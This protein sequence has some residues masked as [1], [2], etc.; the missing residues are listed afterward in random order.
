M[1]GG[2][3]DLTISREANEAACNFM[4]TKTALTVKDP[5]KA[6]KLMPSEVFAR[7]PVCDGGYYEQFN[8]EN[9]NI[10]NIG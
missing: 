5:E 9:V 2:F 10:A 7:R 4:K 3:N 8:R 1:F 6:R